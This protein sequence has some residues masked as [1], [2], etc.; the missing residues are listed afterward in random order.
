MTRRELNKIITR[1]AAHRPDKMG[2]VEIDASLLNACARA[3]QEYRAMITEN[4]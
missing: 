2:V 1:L 3:I 4:E